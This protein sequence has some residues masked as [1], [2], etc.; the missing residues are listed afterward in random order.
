MLLILVA[1]FSIKYLVSSSK[2]EALFLFTF[3]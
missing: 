1:V 3:P 2:T